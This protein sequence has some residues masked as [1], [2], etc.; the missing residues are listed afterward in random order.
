MKKCVLL[1]IALILALCAN[2]FAHAETNETDMVTLIA[3]LRFDMTVEQAIAASGYNL[4]E[5]SGNKR[6]LLKAA[7]FDNKYLDGEGKIGG[8]EARIQVR[9]NYGKLVS[10]VYTIDSG[11]RV[12]NSKGDGVTLERD[13]IYSESFPAVESML[14]EKYGSPLSVSKKLVP[15][16][17][18]TRF[19]PNNAWFTDSQYHT[20][21]EEFLPT[22]RIISKGK[23]CIVIEHGTALEV[24]MKTYHG[25]CS[26]YIA[27]TIYD[28]DYSQIDD[29]P[30]ANS[31][32][33]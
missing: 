10:V 6:E 9:F 7:G 24:N 22:Q 3:N 21:I 5:A 2:V 1:I 12:H 26:H 13:T 4:C 20:T 15:S 16:V 17:F 29:T 8:Y 14:S 31:V 28:E 25:Y 32:G 11:T 33:F 30:S 23:G 18:P 19:Y 27:Y